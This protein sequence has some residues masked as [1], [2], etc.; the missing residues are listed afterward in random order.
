MGS[1]YSVGMRLRESHSLHVPLDDA[2]SALNDVVILQRA[3]PG[4]ESLIEIAR[5]EF[6]GEMAVPMGLLTHHF[7]VYVHRRDVVAPQRCTLHFETRTG[8][9]NGVGSAALSLAFDGAT[10]TTLE[11]DITVTLDGVLGVLGAPLIELAAHEM[12][13][14][15]FEGLSGAAFARSCVPRARVA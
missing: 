1:G 10:A 4:C 12:A 9:T 11:A 14:Q 3:L 13:R 7:T 2:W 15:F 5:D 8:G 6:V